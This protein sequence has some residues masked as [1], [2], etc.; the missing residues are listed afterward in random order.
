MPD[1]RKG[2]IVAL[3][4]HFVIPAMRDRFTGYHSLKAIHPLD[5][6][7][8]L[9]ERRIADMDEAGIDLTVLSHLQPG[10]QVFDAESAVALSRQSNDALHEAVRAHP[11][12]FEGF[13]ALPTA[14]PKAAADELERT[15]TRYGFKGAMINGLTNGAF[16]DEKRFW[17]IFE[18]AQALDVPVYLHPAVSHPAVIEAYYK[19]YQHN[20]YP[21]LMGAV[22]GFNVETSIA[23]L[24]MVISGI[25]DAYPKLRII[26]GHMG[27]TIPYSLWRIEWTHHHLTGKSGI[28][29]CF[30]EHFYVTT[31][32]N[33]SPTALTCCIAEMGIDRVLFSV[34][35]PFNSNV[36]GVA[37][38]R[39]AELSEAD[40]DKIFHGNAARLLKLDG[41]A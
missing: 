2:R 25:F 39:A 29:D 9:G 19:D 33:F 22:W 21:I 27:E 6:L 41:G 24:R 30:R 13:A 16:H 3:E 28:A 34:D 11:G 7:N 10:P 26:I 20:G 35:Y 8:S 4:E 31:S 5:Q 40:R 18:R 12:R 32:G 38:V 36:E 23:A 37:F 15:V 17:P 1:A 14:D